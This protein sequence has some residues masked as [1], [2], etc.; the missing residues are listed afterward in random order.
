MTEIKISHLVPGEGK[1]A[2]TIFKK[3]SAIQITRPNENSFS[4]ETYNYGKK[5]FIQRID[6][7]TLPN[8]KAI[9]DATLV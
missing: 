7:D 3:D 5:T 9:K 2:V 6:L 8:S 1:A 4:I